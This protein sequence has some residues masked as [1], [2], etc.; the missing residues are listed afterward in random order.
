MWP[1]RVSNRG[2]LDVESDALPTELQ[3]LEKKRG[4]EDNSEIAFPISQ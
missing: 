2:L 3:G 4:M 1:D